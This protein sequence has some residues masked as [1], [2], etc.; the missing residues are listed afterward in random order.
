MRHEA[1]LLFVIVAHSG[2]NYNSRSRS[3]TYNNKARQRPTDEGIGMAKERGILKSWKEIASYLGVGVRTA[4]RWKRER[5]LPVKQPGATA[6]SAV[7]GMPSEIDQWLHGASAGRAKRDA[8]RPELSEVVATDSLWNR[9]SRPARLESEIET[10]LELSQL[11]AG[12][13]HDAV[14]SKIS[15]YALHECRAESSG[16][17]ILETADDGTEIFRW[18]ATGGRMRRFEAGTTPANFSPCGVCLERNSPQLFKHPEKAYPYLQPISP[19][20]ELLLIPM[21]AKNEWL[22]T[23]WVI[24]HEKRRHFDREDARLLIDL[25]NVASA[26]VLA[27]RRQKAR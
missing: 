13:N 22:G 17:S 25:G 2:A 21:H 4:Q 12:Q 20:A 11:V 18:T 23:I 8:E 5:G 15:T 3:N 1:P 27:G 24:C 10:L 6:R 9:R 16:F 7:L 26:A 19:I 14:L